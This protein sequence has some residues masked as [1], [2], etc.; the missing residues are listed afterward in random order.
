MTAVSVDKDGNR[1]KTDILVSGYTR[2][3]GDRYGMEIPQEIMMLIFRFWFIAVCDTWKKS[4]CCS[5]FDITNECARLTKKATV[6]DEGFWLC[7]VFGHHVVDHGIFEWKIKF[8]TN[9]KWICI[10]V[11]FDDEEMLKKNKENNDYGFD[12]D[13]GCFLL[14]SNGII[15]HK[16]TDYVEYCDAFTIKD[17][18]ITMTLDID[19]NSISYK[20]ND[21]DY[22]VAYDQLIQDKYRL[23]VTMSNANE[24]IELL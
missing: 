1:I 24:E 15:Y 20:I 17:T 7:S 5:L 21:K 12:K 9:I 14:N 6:E 11:C 2:Q 19:K 23:A 8:N 13:A 10:G 4:L 18:V 3:E 22:G 16:N